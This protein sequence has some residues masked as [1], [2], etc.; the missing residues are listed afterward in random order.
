MTEH[1][2][3]DVA[4]LIPEPLDD[5][6][7]RDREERGRQ[8]AIDLARL[9]GERTTQTSHHHTNPQGTTAHNIKEN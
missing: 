4:R 5:Q 1:L 6:H 2:P 8:L 3:P 9:Q 7:Q